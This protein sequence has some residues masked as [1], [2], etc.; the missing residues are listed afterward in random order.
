[1]TE[2][3]AILHI[4]TMK[5][6]TSSIQAAFFHNAK[7]IARRGFAYC[8]NKT[9]ERIVARNDL[10]KD[11]RHLIISQEGLWHY[12]NSTKSDTKAI[13]DYL[14]QSGYAVKVIV[15]FRRPDQFLEAWFSQGLKH[16]R[17]HPSISAFLKDPFVKSSCDFNGRLKIFTNLFGK[18]AIQ[19][20]PYERAQLLQGDVVM[21]FLIRTGVAQPHETREDLIASGM[22]YPSQQNVSPDSN[23]IL[24]VSLLRQLGHLPEDALKQ[25]LDAVPL[26]AQKNAGRILLQDEVARINAQYLPVFRHLQAEYGGGA[27]PDFFLNWDSTPDQ[28]ITC[29]MRG[30][31]D[32]LI[33]RPPAKPMPKPL[34]HPAVPAPAPPAKPVVKHPKVVFAIQKLAGLMGGAERVFIE[35]AEAMAAQGMDVRIVTFDPTPATSRFGT[36]VVPMRSLFPGGLGQRKAASAGLVVR[37]L[38]AMPNI[39]PLTHVKWRASHGVFTRLLR[40]D[41]LAQ[42][43]DVV[44]AFLPPAITAAGFATAGMATK[45]V[46]STHNVPEQDFGDGPRWDQNPLYRARA[47]KALARAAKVTVLLPEFRAWF[48]Q[49]VQPRVVHMPNPVRR[50]SALV[51]GTVREKIILG[52]GRLTAIKRWDLLIAG[53]AQV[54]TDLPDWQVRLF[55]E[56]PEQ[57]ALQAQITA[58]GMT[59]R[60]HLMG[61]TQAIGG[62]YDRASLLVHPSAFEGFGLSVAEAMAHGLPPVAFADCAG[63]NMLIQSGENGLLL[64]DGQAALAGGLVALAK[65]ESQR[66]RM[67]Q[68]A[69]QITARFD[70]QKIYADWAK[71]LRQAS[72]NKA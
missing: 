51:P 55:G 12:A 40:A 22:V 64:P 5:T 66:H 2:R 18:D 34:P 15:Y 49:A 11:G 60:I 16:G 14:F 38:K 21:D 54:A 56:G 4:G 70:A 39:Y 19:I 52:V 47:R 62:E 27:S 33:D 41:L 65:D 17:G 50:V 71:I 44:V 72:G 13:A 23:V 63:V 36:S 57:G 10:I 28:K 25:A 69:E 53:F 43:A 7:W 1:M 35:T 45:L 31:Y 8:G 67:G 24:L 46:A 37:L 9:L 20:V 58:L 68:A 48:P 26:L 59:G 30:V 42:P 32:A 3:T 29:K 6:G 61:T